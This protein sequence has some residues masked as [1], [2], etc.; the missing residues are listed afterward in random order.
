[1]NLP[2]L[3]SPRSI[4]AWSTIWILLGILHLTQA[5]WSHGGDGIPSGLGDGRFNHLVLEHGYQSLLGHYEWTNPGQFYPTTNTLGWSDSHL[6]TLPFYITLRGL[7][8]SPERAY[9]GWFVLCAAL[10]LIVGFR[11]LHRLGLDP[12]LAGPLSFAAFAGVPAVWLAGTHPQI[13][14]IFP[15]LWALE[16]LFQYQQDRLRSRLFIIGGALAGQFAAGPYLAFFV[17]LA[18]TTA[19]ILFLLSAS[20]PRGTT[21]SPSAQSPRFSYPAIGFA[22]LGG[23]L[24]A[25]NLGVYLGA[26]RRGVERPLREV[27]ELCPTW[28]SWFSASPAHALY[29]TAWPAHSPE[30]SE[31]VLFAGFLP[32][33]L[34]LAAV[35]VGWCYR[36]TPIARWAFILGGTAFGIVLFTV[37]WPH[38]FSF[39]VLAAEHFE[40][41]RGFRAIG[42]IVTLTHALM[43][44]SSGLLITF[45][46]QSHH[47]R[48]V[49]K[50]F[51]FAITS[52][53][54]VESCA[55][56]QPH[57]LVPHALA[58]R[59]AVAAAWAKAG[60]RPILAFAPGFTNQADTHLHLD[61]WAAALSL[62]RVT[63]NG[64]S[65][66][67]PSSHVGF[68]WTPTESNARGLASRLQLDPNDLSIVTT[69]PPATAREIGYEFHS[70]RVLQQLN[71]FDLAPVEWT[72]F[73]PPE[74]F[75]FD[76]Q[77]FY[78]FT[79]NAEV[80]FRLPDEVNTLTFLTGGRP[81]SYSEGGDSD[82]YSLTWSVLDAS[83]KSIASATEEI[84][85]RD[86]PAHRGFLPRII[87]LPPGQSRQ[88]SF[89]FGPGPSGMNNWDWP[90][91]G[92]LRV[93]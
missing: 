13:L 57:Y 8:F 20:S 42:R 84:N 5:I 65:G 74:R 7:F 86:I 75:E 15:G 70:G 67:A 33:I 50:V 26:V 14:P 1:M 39:W 92:R 81:G 63:L 44:G 48:S 83:G 34:T 90:L 46:L 27:I 80:R 89:S 72:L 21:P 2:R 17:G 32:W 4:P 23:L 76:G 64:Y 69:F 47:V 11:L 40:P 91:L 9:Q 31:H 60:N 88:L 71:D 38:G 45:W 35:S 59:T 82:G 73:A 79:P 36:Q 49:T 10:N 87:E 28:T 30:V 56:Q 66:G 78:Q 58:R 18:V 85:P 37:K 54:V 25:I 12:W 6:G 24:G 3:P 22:A 93:D 52:L 16:Q 77:V 19:F 51:I 61:A 62:H 68:I 43:I 55:W 53:L 29:P 41:L